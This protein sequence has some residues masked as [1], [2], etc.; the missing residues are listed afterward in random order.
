MC[1]LSFSGKS[2]VSR[3]L[4]DKLDAQVLSLDAINE[5]RGLDGGQGIPVEEWAETNRIAHQRAT[6]HL[7]LRR[8]VIVDDTGSPR[9]VR[10]QWRAIA[11][12]ADAV[13]TLVWV[14]IDADLQRER[15]RRNRAERARPD[16]VDTVLTDHLANFENPLD[17][18]PLV[19]DARNTT[20]EQHLNALATKIQQ[21]A[22]AR[23]H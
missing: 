22:T 14:Q 8:N 23:P 19:I 5:E 12:E 7:R 13:F 4:A 10:D 21:R 3:A 15:V 20:N 17:E 1:G 9:F 11:H 18:D 16:V 2:T 6:T